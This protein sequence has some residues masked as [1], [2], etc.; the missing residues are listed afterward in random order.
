MTVLVVDDE[1]W[2]KT[3]TDDGDLELKVTGGGSQNLQQVLEEGDS[4]IDQ[5]IYLS[6]P[7]NDRES[8]LESYGLTVSNATRQTHCIS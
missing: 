5:A 1:Y 2:F 7:S 6:N 4:A 3:G 8:A